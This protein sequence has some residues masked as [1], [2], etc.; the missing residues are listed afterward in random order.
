MSRK[1]RVALL[2]DHQ[3]I[4]DGYIHRLNQKPE[5]EVVISSTFGDD[6]SKP[7]N[8]IMLRSSNLGNSGYPTAYPIYPLNTYS[9]FFR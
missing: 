5:I 4:I 8:L 7:E 9:L 1:I 2:D 6:W 3:S